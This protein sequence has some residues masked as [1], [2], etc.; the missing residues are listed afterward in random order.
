MTTTKSRIAAMALAALLPLAAQA[1]VNEGVF[2]YSGFL[3][4]GAGA[5]ET[6]PQSLTFTLCD[7]ATGGN[8][9]WTQTVSVLP[10]AQ[11][12]FSAVLGTSPSALPPAQFANQLW[13]GVKVGSEAEM[14]PRAQ[15]GS[16]P[17]A[18]SVNWSGVL[19][20]PAACT[21][22]QVLQGYTAA[23]AAICVSGGG[24]ASVTK[25]ATAGN[26]LVVG[27]TAANPTIDLPPA[28]ASASGYL[29]SSD[30]SAFNAKAPTG[31]PGTRPSPARSPPRP[32]PARSPAT[33][34]PQPTLP[35]PPTWTASP[36]ASTSR[37]ARRSRPRACPGP[38][39]GT[40]PRPRSHART[41]P[42]R[43]PRASRSPISGCT[44]VPHRWER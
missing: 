9:V 18:L 13:L 31:N 28:S 14:T 36:P 32:S 24:V 7:A 17:S 44:Q 20:V 15:M 12:W 26:P 4:N 6:S 35:T 27:G 2:T 19:N 23:G 40:A 21:A 33:R 41:T 5:V 16:S 1:A 37:P 29:S 8:V 34:P 39:A 30:R 11:G 10:D 22:G 38:A 43:R 25:A 3:K 42:T